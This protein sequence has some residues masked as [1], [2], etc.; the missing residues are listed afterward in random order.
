MSM[1]L[2]QHQVLLI[3]IQFLEEFKFSRKKMHGANEVNGRSHETATKRIS[4]KIETA[5][6]RMSSEIR[7]SD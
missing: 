3:L 6:Q 1:S 2:R 5:M 7:P 4:M